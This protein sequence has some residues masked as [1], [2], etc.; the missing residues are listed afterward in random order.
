VPRRFRAAVVVALR[1]RR[2][3]T[4]FF[5]AVARRAAAAFLVG[6]DWRV[7]GAAD[8]IAGALTPALVR[9]MAR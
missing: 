9:T 5:D 1:D 8:E 3:A 2:A 6:P 7:W 4:A